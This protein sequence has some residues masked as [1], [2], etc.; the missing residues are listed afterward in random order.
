MIS[1]SYYYIDESG[2][3]DN[4]SKFFILSCYKTDTPEEVRSAVEKLYKDILNAPI[5]AIERR[6]LIKQKGF[7]ACVNHPDIK[8][9]FYNLVAVLNIRC[10]VLML[11]KDSDLFRKMKENMSS[12]EIYNACISKLLC[13]RLTK[14]RNDNN[15]IIFEEYGGKP[16][17]WLANVEG[18]VKDICR[19][20]DEKFASNIKCTVDVH[21]KSDVNL[22][23]IDYINHIFVQIF[24]KENLQARILDNF[25]IIEPKIALIYKMDKDHFFDK[26]KRIDVYKY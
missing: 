19:R 23:V 11:K 8:S 14:T 1:T 20:I 7:H 6:E 21:D 2:A 13:D 24:E 18:V 22:S 9:R 3:I 12:T 16:K 17:K 15:I 26:N 5:F 25:T 4:N 10:Y